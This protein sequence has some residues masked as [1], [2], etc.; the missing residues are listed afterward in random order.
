MGLHGEEGWLLNQPSPKSETYLVGLHGLD[1]ELRLG[2][3]HHPLPGGDLMGENE[4]ENLTWV[5]IGYMVHRL[6]KSQ[7]T[8]YEHISDTYGTNLH[9]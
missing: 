1:R 6:D 2:Q 9:S 3:L 5:N 7:L 4:S 8:I